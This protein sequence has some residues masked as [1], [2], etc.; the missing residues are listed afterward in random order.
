MF[1]RS[2]IFYEQQRSRGDIIASPELLCKP[3]KEG[4]P[5]YPIRQCVDCDEVSYGDIFCSD[6]VSY[7]DYDDEG[8]L[9]YS[10]RGNE[11]EPN[12]GLEKIE[13]KT[14][15]LEFSSREIIKKIY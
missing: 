12:V 15:Q 6:D 7:N 9:S 3:S 13:N 10:L 11:T 8:G 14:I 1:T 4:T 2:T 5:E